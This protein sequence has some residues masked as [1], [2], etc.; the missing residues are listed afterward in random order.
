[1]KK[2]SKTPSLIRDSFKNLERGGDPLHELAA[3]RTVQ[4]WLR[5]REQ[6]TLE[7]AREK[8]RTWEE[9]G[10][11]QGRPRQAVHRQ[12]TKTPRR[13]SVKGLTTSD[14]DNIGTADLRYWLKWWRDLARTPEGYEE[15]GRDPRSEQRKIKA[16]LDAREAAGLAGPQRGAQWPTG[17]VNTPYRPRVKGLTS[18]EYDHV[19]MPD[20]RTWKKYWEGVLAGTRELTPGSNDTV[21]MA[22]GEIVKLTTEIEARVAARHGV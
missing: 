4:G 22:P 1:M 9:I 20:I 10:E 14:F 21:E 2:R 12:A 7:R 3:I 17:A 11:A 5:E 15:D 16:E 6:A 13:P 19:G 8:G 18:R